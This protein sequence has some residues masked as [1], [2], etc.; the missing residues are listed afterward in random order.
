MTLERDIHQHLRGDRGYQAV[1]AINGVGRPIA[2]ILVAEI[3]DVSRFPTPAH[4]CSWAGLTPRHHESDT[5]TRRG[6]ISKQGSRLLRWALIEGISRYHGGDVLTHNYQR[7]AKHASRSHARPSRSP[8]TGYA[9]ARSAASRQLRQRETRTR[10]CRE[11]ED[12][13][14]ASPSCESSN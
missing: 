8:T 2:A 4:L 10:S 11:L 1:Q 3:G 13:H 7:I 5:K 14:D 9:T 6:K 12:R